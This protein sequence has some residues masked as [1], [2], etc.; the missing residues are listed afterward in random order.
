MVRFITPYVRKQ[1]IEALL[2]RNDWTWYRLSQEMNMDNTSVVRALKIKHS[3]DRKNF[4]PSLKTIKALAR[5]FNVS[6][7]FFIDQELR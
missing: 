5:A 6:A 3:H 7:G 1:R 2:K 4:D